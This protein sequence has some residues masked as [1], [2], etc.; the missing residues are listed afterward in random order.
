[1]LWA[2][3]GHNVWRAG[4]HGLARQRDMYMAFADMITRTGANGW[5]GWWFPGGYRV[6][7][8]SDYG[9][10]APDRRLRPAAEL[11]R[12]CAANMKGA[13]PSLP[14]PAITVRRDEGTAGLAHL[15]DVHRDDF[16]AA[17]D[18]GELPA[19]RTPGTG[20]T[21]LTCPF[22]GVGGVP[23]E[24]PQPAEYLNAEIVLSRRD[25]GGVKVRL[26]NTGEATWVRGD[27]ALMVTDVAGERAVPLDRDMAWFEET[28]LRI[29][30]VD[31]LLVLVMTSSRFGPFGERARVVGEL[32]R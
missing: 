29:G 32:S 4:T 30:D 21:S 5:A 13:T 18:R 31:D 8:Q 27:C 22:T 12:D 14:G 9:I 19:I 20:T 17:W 11:L 16:C 28:E 25:D 26:I 10:I 2:E 6:D 3:F 1:M 15:V 24:A 23:Y 7:E